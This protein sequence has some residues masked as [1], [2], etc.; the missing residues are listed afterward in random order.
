MI[1]GLLLHLRE[2]LI[3]IMLTMTHQPRAITRVGID[4]H[5]GQKH[6]LGGRY[7][8]NPL[9]Y[10]SFSVGTLYIHVLLSFFFFVVLFY[11]TFQNTK[12][13]KIFLLF[14][15]VCFFRFLVLVFFTFYFWFDI[16]KKSKKIMLCLLFPSA[17]VLKFENPK[18]FVVLFG[19][20]KL[21]QSSLVSM[22]PLEL[23]YHFILFKPHK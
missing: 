4:F 15:F 7:T 5:L 17:L 13:P 9:I 1:M 14:L 2:S 18:I 22:T 8:D 12:R 11:F 6:N 10:T 16:S 20:V 19:F 3:T 23:G 21:L